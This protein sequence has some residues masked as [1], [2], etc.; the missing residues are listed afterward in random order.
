MLS[1]VVRVPSRQLVSSPTRSFKS[2]LVSPAFKHGSFAP[3][4]PLSIR[5]ALC[6]PAQQTPD[7]IM[8]SKHWG[9]MPASTRA[10]WQTL[11]WNQ[12]NWANGPNPPSDNLDWEE[13]SFAEQ[14]AAS[15]LGYSEDTWDEDSGNPYDG[16]AGNSHWILAGMGATIVAFSS[17]LDYRQ[18]K[19]V[20]L[21]YEQRVELRKLVTTL[22]L[23]DRPAAGADPNRSWLTSWLRAPSSQKEEVADKYLKHL[24]RVFNQLSGDQPYI[25]RARWEQLE[26]AA[27]REDTGQH[28]DAA[29]AVCGAV[30]AKGG[31]GMRLCPTDTPTSADKHGGL[32]FRAFATLCTLLASSNQGDVDSQARLV[33]FL[34]DEDADGVVSRDELTSFVATCLDANL[35]RPTHFHKQLLVKLK[36]MAYSGGVTLGIRA[37]PGYMPPQW[38]FDQAADIA[39]DIFESADANHDGV[40][41]EKEFARHVAPLIY[42]EMRQQ[43]FAAPAPLASSTSG[44]DCDFNMLLHVVQEEAK[45]QREERRRSG[46]SGGGGG[47]GGGG[48]CFARGTLVAMADGGTKP[49]EDVKAG[50]HVAEGGVVR[51]SMAFAAGEA[52]PLYVYRGVTVTADHA[53]RLEGGGG[54]CR[55]ADAPG[56]T[57][58][59]V[60]APMVYDLITARHRLQ[61]VGTQGGARLV[62][63]FADYEETDDS[64][65]D[66]RSFLRALAHE[67][68]RLRQ[69]TVL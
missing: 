4:A 14:A 11:G 32:S 43:G 41:D 2:L 69:P 19:R 47:G 60:D 52:A 30:F 48:G 63:T 58:V 57:L 8:R 23:A 16:E 18:W 35:L 40:L 27:S 33:F 54:W 22:E 37:D 29:H 67:D 9:D 6:V 38:C 44:P 45:R 42:E 39:N 1:A 56:A 20:E 15:A 24:L 61:L 49:I 50:E 17:Y 13:L 25:T 21:S 3:R 5:R 26:A 59:S 53:V 36:A 7:G 10:L 31:R 46:G 28:S 55:A 68:R 66:M 64:E 34:V 65:Q 12:Y 51:A 62:T